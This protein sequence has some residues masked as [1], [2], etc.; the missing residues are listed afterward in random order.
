MDIPGKVRNGYDAIMELFALS[1]LH[2]AGEGGCL[3][4]VAE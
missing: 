4:E 2:A 1:R 3:L